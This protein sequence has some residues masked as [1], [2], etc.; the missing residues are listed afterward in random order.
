MCKSERMNREFNVNALEHWHGTKFSMLVYLDGVC[1]FLL[2]YFYF[3]FFIFLLLFELRTLLYANRKSFLYRIKCIC[4]SQMCRTSMTLCKCRSDSCSVNKSE[5]KDEKVVE[6][7]R[8]RQRKP[9]RL[10]KKNFRT[11]TISLT[12]LIPS[13]HSKYTHTYTH[14]VHIICIQTCTNYYDNHI[15]IAAQLQCTH[16]KENLLCVWLCVCVI[17]ILSHWEIFGIEF[18]KPPIDRILHLHTPKHT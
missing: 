18:Q 8:E 14:K 9:H 7:V 3:L 12:I 6:Q 13:S 17:F 4:V 16:I 2:F 5:K 1:V 10:P 11:K 15:Y